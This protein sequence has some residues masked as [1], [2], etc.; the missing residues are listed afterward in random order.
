MARRPGTGHVRP[1]AARS[2][3]A[4]VSIDVGAQAE[5]IGS[6]TSSVAPVEPISPDIV[7]RSLQTQASYR[8]LITSGFSGQDAAG[9]IGY[10]VGLAPGNTRWS[11]TQINWLLVLRDLYSNTEWGETERRPA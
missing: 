7:P 1:S 6:G 3:R 11:L 8:L 10:V 2:D 4:P 9:L 5:P